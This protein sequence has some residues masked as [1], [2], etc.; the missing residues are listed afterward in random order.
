[1]YLHAHGSN[2]PIE[3]ITSS[4]MQTGGDTRG[5]NEGAGRSLSDACVVGG[6]LTTFHDWV[7]HIETYMS[8][9]ACVC[10]DMGVL[11]AVCMYYI[12]TSNL[13]RIMNNLKLLIGV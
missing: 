13:L 5:K 4:S 9:C 11:L 10:M 8:V 3:I 12:Y 7:R 2:F 6:P 1:M